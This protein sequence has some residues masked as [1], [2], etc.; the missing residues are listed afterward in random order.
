[1]PKNSDYTFIDF[2]DYETAN[3]SIGLHQLLDNSPIGSNW[4]EPFRQIANIGK[5]NMRMVTL[6]LKPEY[7]KMTI[8]DQHSV[9]K[10][11]LE[12]VCGQFDCPYFQAFELTKKGNVHSHC[13]IG[14]PMGDYKE[15]T[16][17]LRNIGFIKVVPIYDLDSAIDYCLKDCTWKNNIPV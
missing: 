13:I 5:S 12:N 4:L 17:P 10:V 2:D 7:H 15:F 6:T 1:M 14:M 8:P 11:T 16:K 3:D 9:L